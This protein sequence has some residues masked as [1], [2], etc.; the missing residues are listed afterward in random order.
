MAA[1][2]KE[3]KTK[4]A[5]EKKAEK[6]KQPVKANKSQLSASST[7]YHPLSPLPNQINVLSIINF[8]C[9]LPYVIY[10]SIS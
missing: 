9:N 2:G 7:Y 10:D 1:F 3:I 8:G 6:A 4:S 5:L